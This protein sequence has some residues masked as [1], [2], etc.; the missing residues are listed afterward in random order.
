MITGAAG[1]LGR[2]LVEAFQEAGWRVAAGYHVTPLPPSDKRVWP[3]PLDVTARDQPATVVA[4]IVARW[5]RLDALVNN[6]GLTAD[7]AFPRMS[8][9]AWQR[10]LDV[11]LK[12][13]MAC[14]RAAVW[15]MIRQRDGHLI[16][17]S[18]FAARSGVRGQV[19][20]AAAKAGLIGLTQ[21]LAAELGSRN[22]RANVVLPGLLPTGMTSGLEA[23][24]RD[25]LVAENVLRRM[26]SVAE[27]AQFVVFLAGMRDVSGQIFQLDSRLSRWG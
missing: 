12:G 3:V 16:N 11:N 8:D 25:R 17:L 1:G 14:A 18:S 27:V 24:A 13:A 6:A 22:V 21:S 5:G 19:N 26:N 23:A 7:G 15:P 4:A 20:Y 10:V 2:G 9:E